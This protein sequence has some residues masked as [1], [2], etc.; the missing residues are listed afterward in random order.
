MLLSAKLLLIL[1]FPDAANQNYLRS[2]SEIIGGHSSANGSV[3]WLAGIH[4]GIQ[5]IH[6]L[7]GKRMLFVVDYI[8]DKGVAAS[9]IHLDQFSIRSRR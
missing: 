9:V 1:G 7:I 8:D 4:K 3:Q 6:L 5:L 2:I